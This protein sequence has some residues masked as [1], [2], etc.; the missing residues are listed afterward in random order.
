M[1]WGRLRRPSAAPLARVSSPSYF[2]L[3]TSYSLMIAE[4]QDLRDLQ[5]ELAAA[6]ARPWQPGLVAQA[7]RSEAPEAPFVLTMQ[8]WIDLS[9][10]ESPFLLGVL[11]EG[12]GELMGHFHR[13]LAAFGCEAEA[14]EACDG[15]DWALIGRKMIRAV[16]QGFST[17]VKLAPPSER[18][19]R[20]DAPQDGMGEWLPILACLVGQ[21]GL[22]PADA[23]ALPVAQAFALIAAHRCNTGWRVAGATYREE[24]CRG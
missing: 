2:I 19:A 8:A 5:A 23:L 16:A 11:P 12:D 24:D 10:A 22:R 14:L 21:M 20:L 4:E 3:H 7:F 6:E 15:E 18:A 17:Q 13:A 1:K 9:A